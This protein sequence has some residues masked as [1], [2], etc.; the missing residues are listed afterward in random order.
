MANR[1]VVKDS[2]AVL[3]VYRRQ[4]LRLMRQE[5]ARVRA[6]VRQEAPRRTGN[7][8]KKIG[9]KTGWDSRG[10]YAR[11]YTSARRITRRSGNGEFTSMFRYGLAI[12]QKEQYL[13]RGLARTPRR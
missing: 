4:V 9:L 12:Q 10:P 6:N 2:I 7:L 3:R 5:G 13:E 11:I 1:V 8:R